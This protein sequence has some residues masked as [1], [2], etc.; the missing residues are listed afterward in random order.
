MAFNNPH[1]LFH[2]SCGQDLFRTS[3]G[4]AALGSGEAATGVS[5]GAEVSSEA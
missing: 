3:V 4:S 1:L 2:G 5:V